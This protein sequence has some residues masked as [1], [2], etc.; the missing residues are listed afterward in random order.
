MA[1][2]TELIKNIRNAIYGKD[3]RESIAASIEQCYE[4]AS[5][6]GNANMEVS[7]AR[8][9]FDTLS[10]RLNNSDDIKADKENLNTEIELRKS[11]DNNLKNQANNLQSQIDSLAS[12]SPQV[13]NSIEE[14]TDITRVYVNT[15]DGHWYTYNGTMWVDGGIYQATG[16]DLLSLDN[17]FIK[18]ESITLNKIITEVDLLYKAVGIYRNQKVN[19]FNVDTKEPILG[20][21]ENISC[22]KFRTKDI[23]GA[24]FY[25]PL[26]EHAVQLL[27]LGM[28]DLSSAV[29]FE[30]ESESDSPTRPIWNT[31]YDKD[32]RIFTLSFDSNLG[33]ED[34]DYILINLD[35]DFLYIFDKNNSC[36]KLQE[37]IRET[38][39]RHKLST[40]NLVGKIAN[41][42]INLGYTDIL[43]YSNMIY[44]DC[45]LTGY[46]TSTYEPGLTENTNY[47]VAEFLAKNIPSKLL[48]RLF[49]KVIESPPNVNFFV[50]LNQLAEQGL[51]FTYSLAEQYDAIEDDYIN[52]SKIKSERWNTFKNE[53]KENVKIYITFSYK[54]FYSGILQFYSDV[55][56]ESNPNYKFLYDIKEN[57]PELILNKKFKVLQ[58]KKLFI[59]PQTIAKNINIKKVD[60][61]TASNCIINNDELIGFEGTNNINTSL[62]IMQEDNNIKY[63]ANINIEVV[64]ANAGAGT[65][66]KV[67]FIGDSLTDADIYPKHLKELFD[68]SNE[69]M[70]IELLGTLGNGIYKNEGR[71]GWRAYTYTHCA[72]GADEST[73]DGFYQGS[74]AFWNPETNKFDFSYYMNNNSFSNIDYVFICLGT[75]DISRGDY[76][77]ESDII[78]YY[79]TM[80]NSI[81]DFDSNIKI[82][83]W[84]PP[85]RGIKNRLDKL[86]GLY[87]A[88]AVN[89]YLIN[90]FEG[91]EDDNIFLIPTNITISPYEDYNTTVIPIT[92]NQ[93]LE[94]VTDSV[95][96]N[97]NGYYKIAEVFYYWIKYFATL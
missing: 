86:D 47:F 82:G 77:E 90:N 55:L 4:D 5:K 78:S 61:V 79:N 59:Y 42:Q 62:K 70:N 95:H 46:K 36:E 75:N 32:T 93:E 21:S 89:K 45:Y 23:L 22:V 1:S 24:K 48:D 66:K 67:L 18:D 9:S 12:G 13:A 37:Y 31:N 43:Q 73:A 34:Y 88:L 38:T 91:K 60:L 63:S 2:I 41:N 26:P 10:K 54:D 3:V 97:Q 6:N 44:K 53:N 7:E 8:G 49:I 87:N 94:V 69:P 17:K 72:N 16:L 30:N 81:K 15:A 11:S 71:S 20:E 25:V 58:S 57:Y 40:N 39:V 19:G 52:L 65:T 50:A 64:P 83:L 29:N 92:E 80:I 85:A 76:K 68:E 14:M 33:Y 56:D 35:N 74:N 96:P 84:L 28:D 27:V 51:N